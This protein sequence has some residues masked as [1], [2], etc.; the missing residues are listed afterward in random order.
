MKISLNRKTKK[1]KK[2]SSIR[3][4]TSR[5]YSSD[6]HWFIVRYFILI[7]LLIVGVFSTRV[8]WSATDGKNAAADSDVVTQALPAVA[9]DDLREIFSKQEL[10]DI[11]ISSL[12]SDPEIILDPSQGASFSVS[13]SDSQDL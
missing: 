8:Y 13:E 2:A 4:S 6:F 1:S 3:P 5:L 7:L 11:R 9:E 10:R 12:V